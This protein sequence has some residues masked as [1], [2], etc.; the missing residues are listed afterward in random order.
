LFFVIPMEAKT[1]IGTTDTGG[2]RAEAQGTPEDR[3]FVLDN[4][5]KRLQLPR[6]L[7]DSDIIAERCGVRPL[8]VSGGGNGGRDWMQLS[9]KHATA[10][11]RG[12]K[13][14]TIFGGKLTDCTNAGEAV[15]RAERT[16]RVVRPVHDAGRLGEAAVPGREALSP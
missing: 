15:R 9:R 10:T 8:V 2:D 16:R 11:D 6:P 4:I 12:R 1:V 7:E 13:R 5:N 3:R 14:L